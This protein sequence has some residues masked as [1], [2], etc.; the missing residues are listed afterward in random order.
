MRAWPVVLCARVECVWNSSAMQ[1][2]GSR[3][4]LLSAAP[5]VNKQTGW[6][7]QRGGQRGHVVRSDEP[8]R[9]DCLRGSLIL[10]AAPPDGG[11][12]RSL[13]FCNTHLKKRRAENA[14]GQ[15]V[16]RFLFGQ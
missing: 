4:V 3:P 5:R 11:F 15:R 10:L 16:S 14:R 8:V 6:R 9:C 1:A 12:V 7:G 2:R 13:V